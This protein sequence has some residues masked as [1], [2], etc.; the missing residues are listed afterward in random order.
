M[1]TT[2][3]LFTRTR[4]GARPTDPAVAE[5]DEPIGRNPGWFD[6]LSEEKRRLLGETARKILGA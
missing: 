6:E 3:D 4:K 1:T 5:S 2:A